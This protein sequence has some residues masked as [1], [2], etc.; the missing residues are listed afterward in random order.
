MKIS[1]RDLLTWGGG[2]TAGLLVTPVPWKLMDD[3]AKWT[4]NWPWIPQPARG[5]AE[6]K[7][8][9][10]SLCPQGCGMRVRLAAGWAVGVAGMP[11]HPVNRGALCPLGFGAH[12]LNW[13]PRRLRGVSHRGQTASWNDALAAFR[14]ASTEGPIAIVDGWSRRAASAVFED[15]TRRQ[16]GRY[17]VHLTAE[18]RALEPYA[19]WSGVPATAL[20]YDLEN[21]RTI[22][23]FGAP[24]LDGWGAPGRLTKLWSE[25]AAGMPEPDLR[26]IQVEPALSRT[27]TCA[28]RWVRISEGSEAALAAGLARVLLEERLVA[29]QGPMPPMTLEECADRAG[30]GADAIRELARTMV[31]RG[32]VLAIADG[33]PA[34]AALNVVL[35]AIGKRGGIINRRTRAQSYAPADA[36]AGS[37][38]AVVIDST[39]PWDYVPR[40]GGEV[41]R[42]AAWDGGGSRADWLLPAP[43]FLEELTD[44]PTAPA[45]ARET[46]AIAANLVASPAEVRSA[47]QFL[48]QVDPRLRPEEELIRGRCRELFQARA[49]T[50]RRQEATPVS[51]LASPAKVEE[52]LR[53]GAVWEGGPPRAGGLRCELRE[54]PRPM[55]SPHSAAWTAAWVPPVL[56]PLAAKLYQES[57]LREP[58]AR[59][60]K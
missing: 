48:A 31:E 54:W 15:F 22:V 21:V 43:G 13:H 47:A 25:R 8:S 51:K 7:S 27:A 19:K 52:E 14:K 33:E 37:F 6:V 30:L 53:Q 29:A 34:I 42:F 39:V 17:C 10:C 35:G 50:L 56:P 26:L 36:L 46:Y 55:E 5:P 12:Q 60:E 1:R 45:A 2:L 11:H 58:P 40:S 4:Q 9:F 24:L 16:G 41:F 18:E 3:T 28:W 59:R 23:S 57:S 49:G 44:I 38:R 20:G 32:P